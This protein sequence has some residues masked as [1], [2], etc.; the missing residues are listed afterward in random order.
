MPHWRVCGTKEG[1]D[2]KKKRKKKASF[3]ALPNITR[4]TKSDAECQF[5]ALS[6]YNNYLFIDWMTEWFL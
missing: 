6:V 2:K 3:L 4:Y 5:Y 1:R